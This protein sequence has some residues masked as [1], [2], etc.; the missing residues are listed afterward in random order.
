MIQNE[1]R[2]EVTGPQ[3]HFQA[4]V[5]KWWKQNI[6]T[7]RDH[8]S[9]YQDAMFISSEKASDLKKGLICLTSGLWRPGEIFISVKNSAGFQSLLNDKDPDLNKLNIRM[10]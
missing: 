2:T 5:I 8:F 4:Y 6:L 10:I 7:V 9:S 1:T 3:I